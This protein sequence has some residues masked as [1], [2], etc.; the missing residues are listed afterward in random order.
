MTKEIIIAEV[1]STLV[2]DEDENLTINAST[3]II[4]V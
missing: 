1:I 3:E 4:S 2:I